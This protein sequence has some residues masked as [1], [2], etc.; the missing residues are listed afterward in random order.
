MHIH[1]ICI[2]THPD[3][4]KPR[5]QGSL[6]I[7]EGLSVPKLRGKGFGQ[8]QSRLQ[9]GLPETPSRPVMWKHPKYSEV[10]F[11]I[12]STNNYSTTSQLIIQVNLK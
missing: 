12:S 4:P 6:E 5:H 1:H 8:G 10:I 11:E 7:S 3:T 9:Q 2:P